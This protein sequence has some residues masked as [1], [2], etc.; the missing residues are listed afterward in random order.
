[1]NPCLHRESLLQALVDGELDAANALALEAH[2][3]TCAGC[4]EHY[5]LLHA[6]RTRLSSADL[7]YPA[8]PQLRGRI[9]AMIDRESQGARSGRVRPWWAGPATG[10]SAAGAMAAIAASLLLFQLAPL[11][12]NSLEDQLVANHVR[13]LQANH[14]IDVATSDRHVVKPWFN[15]KVDFAPPVVDLADQGFALAGGRLDYAD[16]REVAALVYRHQAHVINVFVMPARQ[17]PLAWLAHARPTRYSIA[18]WSRGGLECW[19]V[20]DVEPAV[21]ERFRSAF[22][23]RVATATG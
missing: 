9:E 22:Y 15:G 14:L 2:V 16:G 12:T 23:A 1:M 13:S 11:Q 4:S 21:L 3:R 6:V 18:H 5:R 19:A 20:S 17:R 7:D 8:P 10:W